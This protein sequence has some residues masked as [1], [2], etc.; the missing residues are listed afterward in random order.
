M[1]VIMYYKIILFVTMFFV[2]TIVYRAVH[3]AQRE[4]STADM[5]LDVLKETA[6]RWP[7]NKDLKA[8]LARKEAEAA[9]RVAILASVTPASAT[10]IPG[11]QQQSG[12]ALLSS[13]T[14]QTGLSERQPLPE[15]FPDQPPQL[16][17][18]VAGI[19]PESHQASAAPAPLSS[20]QAAAKAQVDYAQAQAAARNPLG[21]TTGETA[22]QALAA[23]PTQVQ[24]KEAKLAQE[25]LKRQ[26]AALP[27]PQ[28]SPV[29]TATIDEMAAARMKGLSQQQPAEAYLPVVATQPVAAA[30]GKQPQSLLG[31]TKAELSAGAR[32]VKSTMWDNRTPLQKGAIVG[33]GATAAVLGATALG[34]GIA[35]QVVK[36]MQTIKLDSSM[37]ADDGVYA[38]DLVYRSVTIFGENH[39]AFK[40]SIKSADKSVS[41]AHIIDE[42]GKSL[43]L[44]QSGITVRDNQ[45]DVKRGFLCLKSI[46]VKQVSGG[47]SSG[48]TDKGGCGS[49]T[50]VLKKDGEKLMIDRQ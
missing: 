37:F 34:A 36:H 8:A 5:S 13:Q 45:I 24:L 11:F 28:G 21:I 33:V 32:A 17:S 22:E 31:R 50:F 46:T 2:S 29:S 12:R 25:K 30:L 35:S 15:G 42:D 20:Q 47:S 16:E 9:Q 3:G 23:K 48:T 41:I 44:P 14:V 38:V 1:K 49:Y 18:I 27:K 4:S 7:E 43:S 40:M 39:Y 6:A 19:Q 26:A 10:F